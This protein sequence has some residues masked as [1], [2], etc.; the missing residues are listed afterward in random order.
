MA[1]LSAQPNAR[2]L[3]VQ[4]N[5]DLSRRPVVKNPDGTI[6]TVRSMSFNEDGREILVPT[7][8][9]DGQLLDENQAIDLYHRTGQHLGMFDNPNDADI[10]AQTL[11]NQQEQM[12]AK[13]QE[14]PQM[15]R[16]QQLST[17]LVNADKAG[18][19]EAAKALAA[20]IIRM[21]GEK[22]PEQQKP[23]PSSR[24]LTYEEGLAAMD[25]E[26]ANGAV[27]TGMM[28]ALEGVPVIGPYAKSGL[29]KL[30]A[31]ISSLIDGESYD[32]NL[33]Q[34]QALTDEAQRAHPGVNTAGQV[35]G[36]VGSMIPLGATGVGARALGI[37]G[38]S[39]GGRLVASGLSSGA[40]SAADT[41][42]RG[43]DL[44]DAGWSGLI[45]GGIGMAIPVV[46]AGVEAGIRGVAGRAAPMI[47]AVTNPEKES[48]RRVGVAVSRDAAANPAG[49]L[50]AA[51]EATARAANIPLVNA[52]RGGEVTRALARSAANQSP[53]ARAGIEKVAS[54]R[55]GGQGQRAVDFLKRVTN[56]NVD[57]LALQEQL[58]RTAQAVN[59]PA[60]KA[61]FSNPAAQ[62]VFTPRIQQLMQ[63]PSFRQ[64]I[65]SVPARSAD[66]GAVQG[67]KEIGNPFAKNS[68]GAYVLRR[69]AD[70][71]TVSPNLEFWNQV[72]INLDEQISVA[73]RAGNNTLTSDLTGLKN[74]LV[75]DLDNVVPA[76]Q[77]ARAGASAFF[78]AEDALEAGRKFA[79]TP[80][81]IPEAKKA[82]AKFTAP[83]REAFATGYA[84]EL[85]DRIKSVGDRT[86][87]INSVFK[88]QSSRESIELALG[89]QRAR[90]IE[91]YVRVEDL[92]DRL[93]GAMG[94]STTARQLVELGI[95]AGG[96]YA[97]TGGDWKGAL[98]GA[99]ALKG[100]RYLGERADAKVMENVAKLLT[101]DNPANIRLA[102]Q[103]AS[104]NPAY[105]RALDSLSNKL[106]APV[107]GAALAIGAQ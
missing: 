72:K 85:I 98:S 25:A 27:G 78:G 100:A 89:P 53:E 73:K 99:L 45:G 58:K 80:R 40:I 14:A 70:G 81:G 39:L 4:G 105:M 46:G 102:V 57:D 55:F 61:A 16:M 88:N 5:I 86:N 17:A 84:S 51:D 76:Y 77:T 3:L 48:L 91:A 15:D 33:K 104:K 69:A 29:Q 97:L 59:R 67:F 21:R 54:D 75:S 65:D 62:Q 64:A 12:Y 30:S 38:R 9:P 18:D 34:A 101:S 82:F 107:R 41:A 6:S 95:G 35:A 63:S 2:G 71:T 83:E 24:H 1:M 60:Y 37:T 47:S 50:T 93:R 28:G 11:H 36:A 7:V 68:Q 10:Y 32:T 87:V 56:G 31:G 106:G 43:G 103:Q 90:E 20:E 79:T 94:N 26:G 23:K 66:R 92:A 74:A 96:G 22:Q 42:A 13:P 19:V 8:S 52:D 49:V 44:H